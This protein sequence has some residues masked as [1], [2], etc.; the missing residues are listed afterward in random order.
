MRSNVDFLEGYFLVTEDNHIFEVKG[1]VHPADRV[2]AYLRYVPSE[3]GDRYSS[4]GMRYEKVYSL[5][6]RETYLTDKYPEYLWYDER[7]G[8]VLQSV[9]VS[10]I[11]FVLNPVTRLGQMKDM[12]KH[13]SALEKTSLKLVQTFVDK[14]GL[15]WSNVGITGSQL[16]GLS[17]EESDIDVVVYGSLS[18]RRLF[19]LL[20]NRGEA[21][22]IRRYSG[23]KLDSHVSFR[24]GEENVRSEILTRIESKKVLQGEFDSYDFF[25]RNVKLPEEIA[26]SYEDISFINKGI[27]TVRAKVLDNQDCIFTPCIY[28]VECKED[29]SLKVLVSYRG[30]FTEQ[31]ENGMVVE[32]RGRVEKVYVSTTKEEFT[33]LVL[34]EDSDDYMVP[35]GLVADSAQ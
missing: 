12:G 8:R 26:Y 17:T 11:A 14:A 24:W 18:A 7:R 35:V 9:P 33:Q 27:R 34:G 22:G 30:K 10:R 1:D 3:S 20:R 16:A 25:V 21:L 32:A 6:E 23:K 19:S 13:L 5:H 15:S 31:A 28:R 4:T 29:P 2:I